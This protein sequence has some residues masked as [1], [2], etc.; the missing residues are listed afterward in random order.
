MNFA[1]VVGSVWATVKHPPLEG[2]KLL[3]VQIVD[4]QG[5]TTGDPLAALDIVGA[6]VGDLVLLITSYEATIPWRTRH[7]EY[8]TI[9]IDASVVGILDRWPLSRGERA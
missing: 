9:G 2:G 1:R 8:A 4:D 7:P 3:M 5:R 6:G